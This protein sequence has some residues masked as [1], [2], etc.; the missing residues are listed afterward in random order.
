MF[1]LLLLLFVHSDT[2]VVL[3][4]MSRVCIPKGEHI[5]SKAYLKSGN[6]PIYTHIGTLCPLFPDT[7]LHQHWLAWHLV[8]LYLVVVIGCIVFS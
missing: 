3:C 6:C 8:E 4:E 7:L 1:L 5:I 2:K